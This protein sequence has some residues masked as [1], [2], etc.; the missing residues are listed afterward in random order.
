MK[1]P[2][3]SKAVSAGQNPKFKGKILNFAAL[4]SHCQTR[5]IDI[6]SIN[7]DHLLWRE[8][9]DPGE[10]REEMGEPPPSWCAPSQSGKNH[11][12]LSPK[13]KQADLPS[14][15]Q[16]TTQL[17]QLIIPSMRGWKVR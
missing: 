13:L 4:T 3:Y 5:K 7:H 11:R 15:K 12:Q 10:R 14:K 6:Q 17:H 9:A 16:P 8:K 1:I 2:L